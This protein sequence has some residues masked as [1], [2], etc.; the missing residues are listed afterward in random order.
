VSFNG[1]AACGFAAEFL[2]RAKNQNAAGPIVDGYR[3]VG[4]SLLMTG[5]IAGGE[6]ALRSRNW[7]RRSDR[8]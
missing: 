8:L 1:D 7:A 3:L 4:T 6:S 5:D 2:T